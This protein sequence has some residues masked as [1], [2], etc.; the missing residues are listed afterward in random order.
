MNTLWGSFELKASRLGKLMMRQFCGFNVEEHL[1]RFEAISERFATLPLRF[2][3]FF[4]TTDLD[5]VIDAMEYANNVYDVKHIIID[6]L[7]FMMGHSQH[8]NK[9]DQQDLVRFFRNFSLFLLK[10]SFLLNLACLLLGNKGQNEKGHFDVKTICVVQER[11]H[12]SCHSPAKGARRKGARN[13]F[14]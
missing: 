3:R 10:C 9:F 14:K 5:E 7:Q 4:G 13:C 8:F 1:D 2:L 11:S 6:N 12:Y